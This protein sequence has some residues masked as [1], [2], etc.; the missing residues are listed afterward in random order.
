MLVFLATPYSQLCDEKY[1]VK[2]KYKIF[3]K[4][5]TNEIKKCM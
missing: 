2:E 1:K 3:F 5:L 4:N